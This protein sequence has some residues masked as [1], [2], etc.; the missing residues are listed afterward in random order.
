MGIFAVAEM[1]E[2]VDAAI[3]VS[4]FSDYQEVAREFL[5]KSWLTWLF[6]WPLSLTINNDYRPLDFVGEISPVPVLFLYSDGDEVIP[7]AQIKALYEVAVHPKNI[8]EVVGSHNSIMGIQL[9]R[10]IIIRHLD[11]WVD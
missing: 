9:N 1:K 5:S 3:F 11:T 10:D 7:S 8:E 2:Y 4:P 6:Q